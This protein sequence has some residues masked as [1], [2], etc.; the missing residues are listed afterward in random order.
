MTPGR[1]VTLQ[2]LRPDSI[3]EDVMF[4]LKISSRRHVQHQKLERK[5]ADFS[6]CSVT[7]SYTELQ[8]CLPSH[9]GSFLG[10]E[11]Q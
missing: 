10:L 9:K 5:W 4:L 3:L 7:V 11:P 1:N 6:L 8:L 2:C